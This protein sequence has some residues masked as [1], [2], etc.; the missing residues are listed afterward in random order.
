[1]LSL[2]MIKP[3]DSLTRRVV[4]RASKPF[5]VLGVDG[6]GEGIELGAQPA[7][8]PSMVQTVTFKC[9]V[10]QEGQFKKQLKIKTDI[11]ETPVLVTIEGTTVP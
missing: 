9:S 6:L 2:G 4:V 7:S 10:K 5:K 8:E 3:E 1:M 11:Q